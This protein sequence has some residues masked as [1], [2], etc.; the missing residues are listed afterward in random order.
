MHDT[1]T[2]LGSPATP[3]QVSRNE[4][5]CGARCSKKTNHIAVGPTRSPHMHISTHTTAF[6][7][8]SCDRVFVATKS[9]GPH[10]FPI[11]TQVISMGNV[12]VRTTRVALNGVIDDW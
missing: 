10:Q 4:R 9:D 5:C 12:R 1:D 8:W 11:R 7:L 3:P 6:R 2:V